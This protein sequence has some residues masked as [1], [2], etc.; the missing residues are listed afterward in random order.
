LSVVESATRPERI[1]IVDDDP[2][3]E[4][5]LER[6]LTR[7]GY[8]CCAVA[9]VEAARSELEREHFALVLC[10]VQLPGES[11]LDFLRELEGPGTAAVMISGLHT[12]GL[13]DEALNMGAY[14]YITKPFKR[15]DVAIAVMNALR[16]RR[17]EI[18]NRAHRDM[19]EGLVAQRTEALEAAM[20][21]L[22][23][24]ADELRR[25]RAETIWRL[26]RAVEFRDEQTGGHIDR[27]SRYCELLAR[28]IGFDAEAIRTASPMH[29]AGKI[30][31]PDSVL[32]KPGPL[33]DAERR[34]MQRHTEIGFLLLSDSE[35]DLLELAAM[36]ALTHHERFD[37]GGYPRGLRGDAIPVEGQIA[38][39]AD[40]FDA[41]TS[42]RVYRPA[43]SVDQSVEMMRAERGAQFNPE[44]LDAFLGSMEE[45]LAIRASSTDDPTAL[46]R[47]VARQARTSPG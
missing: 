15:S 35:S 6:I 44:L 33:T 41:L 14:G 29:D 20:G 25:S 46:G 39:I 13:A 12:P 18:E 34:E 24:N 7:S 3:V 37:G 8:D 21:R 45:V 10:D 1:L 17:L 28:H 42:D 30:A 40:V 26:S 36:I 31:V 23:V 19:L 27:M 43:F 32:L 4:R 2:Q 11:G 16:R 22:E 47:Y 38:A 5:L 9:S